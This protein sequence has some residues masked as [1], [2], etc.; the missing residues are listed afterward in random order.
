MNS[1]KPKAPGRVFVVANIATGPGDAMLAVQSSECESGQQPIF[2][3]QP[4]LMHK[5]Y[6]E[7]ATNYKKR[8]LS[9][10]KFK[11]RPKID[12]IVIIIANETLT[13][14]LD[15]LEG[16]MF[17][18]EHGPKRLQAKGEQFGDI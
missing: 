8:L 15:I 12:Q 16:E 2:G 1:N 11:N 3:P 10:C 17:W 9:N 5:Y 6:D 7:G 14:F 4:F 13:L 18:K